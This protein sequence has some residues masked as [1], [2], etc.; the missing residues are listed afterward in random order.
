MEEL[1]LPLFKFFVVVIN[2]D[3]VSLSLCNFE[4]GILGFYWMRLFTFGSLMGYTVPARQV[5]TSTLLTW[6]LL[7]N[8][9]RRTLHPV[10]GQGL[11]GPRC[12]GV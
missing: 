10:G 2:A 3:T 4:M 5:I 12:M 11:G 1:I 9:F 8:S 6:S 7:P